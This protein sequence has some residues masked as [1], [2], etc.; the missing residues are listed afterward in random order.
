MIIAFPVNHT[1][2]IF[3]RQTEIFDKTSYGAFIFITSYIFFFL[4]IVGFK[5]LGGEPIN[6]KFIITVTKINRRCDSSLYR[7]VKR[8]SICLGRWKIVT[9]LGDVEPTKET[10]YATRQVPAR[11]APLS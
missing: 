6:V 3:I 2:A 1:L 11:S 8:V 10:N 9:Y 5:M 4:M 7:D